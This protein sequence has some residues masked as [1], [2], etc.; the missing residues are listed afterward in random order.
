MGKYYSTED[1]LRKSDQHW[2]LSGCAR[3]D[4]DMQDMNKHAELAR[5]WRKRAIEGGYE[6]I[7]GEVK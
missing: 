1:C 6:E 4:G 3:C 7:T 5:I 2:E